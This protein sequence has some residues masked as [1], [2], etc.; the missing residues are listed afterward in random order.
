M[1]QKVVEFYVETLKKYSKKLNKEKLTVLMQVGEFFEIYGLVYPDGKREG[2]IWEFCDNVNLKIAEKKQDVY[3]NPEITVYMGGVGISYVNPYIQKAV[4]RFGWTV[5]IFEQSRIGNTAKFERTES[6]IISPGININSES[7]SNITM[8]IYLEQTKNYMKGRNVSSTSNNISNNIINIGVSFVDCL[9]GANG[10]MAINNSNTSDISIPFDELLKLLTIKNPNE[11]II[12]M[13]NFNS[14][15]NSTNITDEDLINAL[16]LFNYQYKIIREPIEANYAK[17]PYQSSI[18]NSIYVKHRGILDILQQLDIEG[19]AHNYSRIA[20]CLLLDF[21]IKHDKS[22]IEKLERPEI[23]IN[24]DKYLM[25]ANNCLEQ[26]DIIDNGSSNSCSNSNSNNNT[27]SRRLSLLDLLDNTKTALGKILLRQR[28][29]MPITDSKLLIERYTTI[30]ELV[31][32]HNTHMLTKNDKFGSPLHQLRSHLSGIKNI[33]NYLRKI[34]THKIQPTD[35]ENY[36]NSLTNCIKVYEYVSRVLINNI[37]SKNKNNN[38][39]NNNKN[40]TNK[41]YNNQSLI[42]NLVPN[43]SNYA[44]FKKLH[45][46]FTTDINLDALQYN[47]WRAIESNPFKKGVSSKLDKLQEEIDN[48]RGFLDNLVLE[49]SKIIDPS[50]KTETAKAKIISIGENATKGIHIYT[51]KKNKDILEAYFTK[52]DAKNI[53]SSKQSTIIIGNYTIESKNIKF[54]Q[55]KESKWEI[56]I[57]YLKTS[58]GT[59]KANIDKMGRI[60]KEEFVKWIHEKII[61]NSEVLNTLNTFARFI[62]EIDLLQSNTLN[63]VEK[64]YVAPVINIDSKKEYDNLKSFIKVD[65]IRHPIIEHITTNAKYVP[66]D[67][68]MGS[69]GNNNNNNNITIGSDG[70]LLFGVNAV[71]KSSLMKS[72][73]INVIMAQAG[74]YVA[75]SKFEYKPYKYLFTRIRNNDNLYAGLSSFEVEMKEFKIILKYANEDSII[76][77]DELC[78]GTNSQDATALVAAGV[79]IL[80]K[81]RCSFI[82]ATHLHSLS[83]MPEITK[84]SNVKL[85]HML[86]EKDPKDPKKLIYSRKIQPGS[87]PNSYGILVCESMNLDDEFIMKAKEIRT[88]MNST[89]GSNEQSYTEIATLGSKYNT[90]KVIA[91]CEVC[92][93]HIATDVHH[94]NQQCD[95]NQNG[96]IND[97]E[98]GIFNKNK[99]WNLVSLCKECHIGVHNVPS[100]LEIGG[101]INTSNGIELQYKW[102]ELD[103]CDGCDYD[104]DSGSDTICNSDSDNENSNNAFDNK[105]EVETPKP[106]VIIMMEKKEKEKGNKIKKSEKEGKLEK[107]EKKGI[108]SITEEIKEI[109]MKMKIANYTPKKIQ[110]DL[111]RKYNIELTQHQ[112]RNYE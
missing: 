47:V 100:K 41:S 87:G 30:G 18:F 49:L 102:L 55:M 86:V 44:I 96:I 37:T 29:S 94:I 48:D 2:N 90:N 112:V 97:M 16:H 9:T 65:K 52:K 59:L 4:E 24:N 64:G 28:L 93:N 103:G 99:L 56:D 111:K 83:N 76:L 22:I 74:M 12:Y 62:G 101:Y 68:M 36:I 14:N 45:L 34:I 8:I 75:A 6:Q 69:A 10:V 17:I 92:S 7:F 26:L 105:L 46:T 95:A 54:T 61:D 19:E 3:E 110:F 58:N 67:V 108:E 23:V 98:N 63:A 82:F 1:S 79:G 80:S 57:I 60:V 35:I 33:D 78:S 50:Y 40:N 107:L 15:S 88:N 77:G 21:I 72:I 91:M 31:E 38:N 84:L 71:G 53:N 73:G 43:E 106:E 81:R 109:I 27:S 25:L 13:E 32:L 20:L 11:L 85:F 39:N 51:T 66:N 5:V 42:K 104:D 70:M 89:G